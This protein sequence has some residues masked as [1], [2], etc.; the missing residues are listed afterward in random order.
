ME[1]AITWIVVSGLWLTF[2]ILTYWLITDADDK[3]TN[4][5]T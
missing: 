3:A 5:K 1:T 4:K 2:G